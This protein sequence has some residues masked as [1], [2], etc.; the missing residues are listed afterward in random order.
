MHQQF[1]KIEA[2][3]VDQLFVV[4]TS[5]SENTLTMDELGRMGITRKSTADALGNPL[6]GYLCE[7]SDRLVGFAMADVRSGEFSVIAVLPEHERRGVGRE[8]LRL[9][10][11]LLWSAGHKTIWLW[12]G[13][14]RQTRALHLYQ[15]A[16]WVETEVRAERIY[17]K[18]D[19]PKQAPLPTPMSVTPAADAP[20]APATP[21]AHP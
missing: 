21:A 4:R 7:V 16:G 12:T 15:K 19:R 1:R 2:G 5:V 13:G 10:E 17:L 11:E 8:L 18:K 3:D 9:T 14:D 6:V 20:V